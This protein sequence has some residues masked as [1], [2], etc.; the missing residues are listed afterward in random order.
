MQISNPALS[1]LVGSTLNR[2]QQPDRFPVRPVTIEGQIVDDEK[3]RTI[4][5]LS[6]DNSDRSST[7]QFALDNDDEQKGL[8]KPI[9]NPNSIA[10]AQGLEPQPN[11]PTL[12]NPSIQQSAAAY[13]TETNE[14]G[15]PFANRRS[16]NGLAGPSLIIQSYL[17]NAPSS[18]TGE[19]NN[20][21]VFV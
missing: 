10:D 16:F 18:Q 14:Q 3:K 7:S 6:E 5:N 11:N 1:Q 21:D 8:I 17:N 4:Q 19:P 15:F 9:S 2:P 12:L 20:I 13:S